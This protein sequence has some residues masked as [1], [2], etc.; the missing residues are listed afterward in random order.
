MP[1]YD[2]SGFREKTKGGVKECL[3]EQYVFRTGTAG[4]WAKTTPAV[5]AEC[6]KAAEPWRDYNLLWTCVMA[7][8][9][10]EDA[11]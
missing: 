8:K 11:R 5:R 4:N 9:Y 1:D 10:D 3:N 7:H 6:I 2:I